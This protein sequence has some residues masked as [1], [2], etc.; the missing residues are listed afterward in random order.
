[1]AKAINLDYRRVRSW[2]TALT[3]FA[4][5]GREWTMLSHIREH[6][7]LDM[8]DARKGIR[9]AEVAQWVETA[10]DPSHGKRNLYR[11]NRLG[12]RAAEEYRGRNEWFDAMKEA[13]L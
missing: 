8:G 1:M 13:G 12:V 7:L 4:L 10:P 9:S 2:R 6:Q 11:L 3:L 5:E